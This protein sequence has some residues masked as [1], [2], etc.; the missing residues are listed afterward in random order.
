MPFLYYYRSDVGVTLMHLI[1]IFISLM[2]MSDLFLIP[3][4]YYYY[5][6][7]IYV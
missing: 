6:S 4:V 7:D 1:Y 3:L 5:R 2:L